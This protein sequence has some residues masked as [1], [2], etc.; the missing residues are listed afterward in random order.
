MRQD[1]GLSLY[2]ENSP[3]LKYLLLIRSET[4]SFG[5]GLLRPLGEGDGVGAG[6]GE[7]AGAGDGDG[8]GRKGVLRAGGS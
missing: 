1:V 8:V 4:A 6:A 3:A 7:G 2:F 5:E